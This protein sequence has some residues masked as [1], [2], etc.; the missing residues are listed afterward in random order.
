MQIY[1]FC[2]KHRA[3][4]RLSERCRKHSS[5]ITYSF[6]ICSCSIYF[7]LNSANVICPPTD[8]LNYFR[9]I[10][11]D[12]EITRVDHKW[13][14]KWNKLLLNV[15]PAKTLINHLCIHAVWPDSA[16]NFKK[17]WILC[18]LFK[19]S[20]M[21]TDQIVW[22]H[23]QLGL[24]WIPMYSY[25]RIMLCSNYVLLLFSSISNHWNTNGN[26]MQCIWVWTQIHN[27]SP[28]KCIIMMLMSSCLMTS[29]PIRVTC[30]K[31]GLSAQ[32]SYESDI[33]I[34]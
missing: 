15:H 16:L 7:F 30:V 20:P 13:D 22:M 12:F 26:K 14:T 3:K 9:E 18:Y 10:P 17:S 8:I 23:K 5:Q 32:F 28:T 2:L 4:K 1:F 19:E 33:T 24:C 34:L 25:I 21:K 6:V 31:R 11:L 27:S 29:Q